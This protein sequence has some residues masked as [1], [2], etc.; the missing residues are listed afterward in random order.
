MLQGMYHTR[1]VNERV[2]TPIL[3]GR[4][5]MFRAARGY[6]QLEVERRARLTRGQYWRIENGYDTATDPELRRI[7]KVLRVTADALAL[8]EPEAKSA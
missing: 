5:R 1:P 8:P 6:S 4:L 2:S 3:C 7:A